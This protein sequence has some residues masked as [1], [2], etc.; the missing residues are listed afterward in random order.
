[1]LKRMKVVTSLVIMLALFG[2]LQL[3]SG[4]LFF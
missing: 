1:M 3:A 2:A 4:G